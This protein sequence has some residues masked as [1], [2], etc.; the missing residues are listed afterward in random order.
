M[1][2]GWYVQHGGKQYGPLPST[3]LK[4]LAADGK[5]TPATTVHFGDE[6]KWI[7]RRAMQGLF[8]PAR[9]AAM[10][11]A[12]PLPAAAAATSTNSK[13]RETGGPKAVPANVGRAP[14]NCSSPPVP[15]PAPPVLNPSFTF[16]L[17]HLEF[18]R[19]VLSPKVGQEEKI[20]AGVAIALGAVLLAVIAGAVIVLLAFARPAGANGI[21]DRCQTPGAAADPIQ[22]P[23]PELPPEP[24]STDASEPIQQGD[25][26]A[27][28]SASIEMVAMESTDLSK[29]GRPKPQKML[30]IRLLLG[31]TSTGQIME[32]PG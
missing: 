9:Q 14:M 24:V 10:P 16:Q 2:N 20:F 18:S 4:Q 5:I 13:S 11:P 8:T 15:P 23:E 6:G 27:V 1:A 29:L 30:K 17:P 32:V 26:E 3:K 31:N 28:K 25:I 21:A 22:L 12:A 7:P 19:Q